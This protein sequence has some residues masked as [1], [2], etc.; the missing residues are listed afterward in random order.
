MPALTEPNVVVGGPRRW[1]SKR[2]LILLAII[3]G[4]FLVAGGAY[5]LLH[6][7]KPAADKKVTAQQDKKNYDDMFVQANKYRAARKFQQAHDTAADYEKLAQN[8]DQKTKAILLQGVTSEQ[9]GRN[10]QALA[11]YRRAEK[12]KPDTL[13]VSQGIA[14]TSLALGDKKTAI[15]YYKKCLDYVSKPNQGLPYEADSYKKAIETLE[16]QS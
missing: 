7:K 8:Q 11:E 1:W 10:E 4:L 2:L 9:L 16:K 6:N 5:M 14:R 13:G 15:E 3:A 12:I